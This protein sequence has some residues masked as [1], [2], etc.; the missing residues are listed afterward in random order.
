MNR[1][2]KLIFIVILIIGVIGLWKTKEKDD[3]PPNANYQYQITAPRLISYYQGQ[4]RW[5]LAAKSIIKP[6]DDK[7]KRTIL[8]TVKEGKLFIDGQ[9]EYKLTAQKIIYLVKSKN[10]KLVGAVKLQEIDGLKIKADKLSWVESKTELQT[11]SGV[12]VELKNGQLTA[13]KMKLN[14]KEGIIDFDQNVK[15]NFKIRGGNSSEE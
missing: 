5:D 15:F 4:K 12:Q 6:K 11:T 13:Q 7:R 1:R 10:A 3:Q 9:L 8:Q 14:L 2:K